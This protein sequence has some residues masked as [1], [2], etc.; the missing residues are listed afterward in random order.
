[1]DKSVIVG[2]SGGVDS[3]LTAYLL[4][5]QGY[6]VEGVS[7]ILFD[8]GCV[9]V[10]GNTPC[11]SAETAS[12][13]MKTAESIGVRHTCV[14]MRDEFSEKVIRPF[15]AAYKKGLT[16][17]PCILCNTHI[18]FPSLI[19][20]ADEKGFGFIATG[21]YART[22]NEKLLRGTDTKKDQSYVLYS[23]PTSIISRMI[24]PLGEKTKAEVRMIAASL[25]MAAAN[26]P[27]SQEICFVGENN[28]IAFMENIPG[29][30]AASS[31]GEIIDIETGRIIGTHNGI[32]LFTIGQRK[33]LPAMGTPIYVVK[34][35]PVTNMVYTG[36]QKM[37]LMKDFI[38]ADVNWLVIP[39]SSPVRATVKV[40]SMMNDEPA[41]L[42]MNDDGTVEVEFDEPQW[43][44]APGQSAVFYDGDIVLGGG[45]I[46]PF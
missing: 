36:P 35:D 38:A 22:D 10:T 19:R 5:E 23:L 11:C 29:G 9:N 42:R 28:Y 17:N 15:V 12:D 39:K 41:L 44:P 3:S 2:M 16:P 33:R 21:H 32:H 43:A 24:L 34:V 26:R 46:Q 20:A 18:K 13:A 1:M 4:K 45:V 25:N 7:L 37:A 14:D 27:E 8:K 6:E 30:A 31:K 40:R